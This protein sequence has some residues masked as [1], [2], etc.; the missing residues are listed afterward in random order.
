MGHKFFAFLCL[1]LAAVSLSA[2]AIDA[3]ICDIL[4][5]PSSFD[6]KTVRITGTVIAGFD[7]FVIK[8][9]TCKQP[10]NAIWLSYPEGA[11]AKA[12]PVAMLSLQLAKNSPATVPGM[13]YPPVSLDANKD[14]KRFESLLSAQPKTEGRCLGCIRSTVTATLTGRLDGIDNPHLEKDGKMFIAVRG[15]GN[16]NRYAA[17]LVLQSVSNVTA[18]EI[19]YSQPAPLGA[20]DIELGLSPEQ[21]ARAAAAYGAEGEENGV[22]I[23]FNVGNTVRKSEAA[24]GS[25]DSPDGLLLIVSFDGDRLKGPALAEAMA[26]VGTH[27]ADLRENPNSR[28]LLQ[29][30]ARAWS[31]TILTAVDQKE[32]VLMLPGGYVLW[33][34]AWSEADRQKFLPGAVSGYV[35]DWAAL[36]R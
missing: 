13:T 25:A 11:R 21:V 6:G 31:A 17:R 5:H 7:E 14:F 26:H 15:F 2:E 23:T 8:D 29:L 3:R 32:K 22:G 33:N 10:V 9:N 20:G 12:G 35:T 4:A 24:K 19:D 36:G 34:S 1:V 27:I 18:N 28:T 30:E 16:L